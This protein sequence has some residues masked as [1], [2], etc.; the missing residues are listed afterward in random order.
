M[1][2]DDVRVKETVRY[3]SEK[4]REKVRRLHEANRIKNINAGGRRVRRVVGDLR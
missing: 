2:G 4:A 3:A 1:K